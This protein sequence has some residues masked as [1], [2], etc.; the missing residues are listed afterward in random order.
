VAQGVTLSVTDGRWP[1]ARADGTVTD[2]EG[3]GGGIAGDGMDGMDGTV[4]PSD[5]MACW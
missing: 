5:A 2:E 4:N 1:D 3:I